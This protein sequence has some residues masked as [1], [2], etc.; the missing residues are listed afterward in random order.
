MKNEN[1][2]VIYDACESIRLICFSKATEFISKNE[3][4]NN[5]S[6]LK[7]I[8]Y[9]DQ[10]SEINNLIKKN[11]WDILFINKQWLSLLDMA[12]NI[13]CLYNFDKKIKRLLKTILD[14]FSKEVK[15]CVFSHLV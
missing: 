1:N 8:S 5:A 3:N 2:Q 13:E 6:A 11:D 7:I 10:K 15:L 9:T 14:F 12:Y 4:S